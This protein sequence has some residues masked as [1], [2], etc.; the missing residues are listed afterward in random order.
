MRTI[1][2]GIKRRLQAAGSWLAL[3]PALLMLATLVA[4]AAVRLLL[5]GARWINPDEGAHLLDGRLVWQGLQPVID[6]GSRQP[7]YAYL[8]ALFIK[9]GG[10]TLSAGRLLPLLASLG[11]GWLLYRLGARLADPLRGWLAAAVWLFLPLVLIWSTVVKTEMPAIFFCLLS[12]WLLCRATRE[13][14]LWSLYLLS[15]IA[16]A[17]AY[18]VRQSTLYL[19]LATLLFLLFAA[20]PALERRWRGLG[21]YAAG[22]LGVCLLAAFYY[23]GPLSI[24]ELAFS[25]INPLNLVWNRLA[26]TLGILPAQQRVVDSEGF[27]ILDQ[28]PAYTLAA[29][30]DAI[31]FAL[32]IIAA[33]LGR[34]RRQP[35]QAG[36]VAAAPESPVPFRRFLVLWLVILLLA[37]AFQSASRGF[38]TQY[39]LEA[40]PPLLLLGAGALPALRPAEGIGWAILPGLVYGAI[41]L[42][43][44]VAWRL[45][46]NGLSVVVLGLVLAAAAAGVTARRRRQPLRVGVVLAAAAFFVSAAWSGRLITPRYE[47]V[48]APRT[49]AAVERLL[50]KE[51]RPTDQVLSG[52]MV[53]T[54]A[55]GLQPYE[56]ISHPT[57]YFMKYDAGF[58]ARFAA[59]PPVFIVLDG[60]TEKKFSRYWEGIQ[61]ALA[62][63]YYK[64][65]E[66]GGSKRP[67]EVWRL[68]EEPAAAEPGQAALE[69]ARPEGMSMRPAD[70]ASRA[71][72]GTRI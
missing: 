54:Y 27:R 19:P 13:S 10:A 70:A 71:A 58:A 52:A 1:V 50:N 6:Y 39:F 16:A 68:Q 31:L 23:W 40:L 29:W 30:R 41:L 67:V 8:L 53:W 38:Y 49:L 36:A 35:D 63:E 12:V 66:A 59:K 26:H 48:W 3:R 60:Y 20:G 33:A 64:V 9:L 32:F 2:S 22:Y 72:G 24:R 42:L 62:R 14:G 18:Y 37:Y 5:L 57:L 61:A 45:P 28:N 21:L 56:M 11:S 43:F 17:L 65:G 7:L 25:Q 4:A 15:G 55:A 34:V 69:P 51:S 46:L 47:C 44:R